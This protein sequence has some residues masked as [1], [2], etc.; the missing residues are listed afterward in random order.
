MCQITSHCHSLLVPLCGNDPVLTTVYATILCRVMQ[1]TRTA[2][3]KLSKALMGCRNAPR[4]VLCAKQQDAL[5]DA[6]ALAVSQ[7]RTIRQ[8]RQRKP[9]RPQ[10]GLTRAPCYRPLGPG[11]HPG[12]CCPPN[13]AGPL[14]RSAVG[15]CWPLTRPGALWLIPSDGTGPAPTN[16]QGPQQPTRP[17]GGTGAGSMDRQGW[18]P[19]R[20]RSAASLVPPSVRQC[21]RSFRLSAS[22][23]L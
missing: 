3:I 23:S 18:T 6:S 11:R 10:P 16:C 12:P 19:P 9:A 1:H 17:G 14:C 20:P 7:S 2:S 4:V 5:A 21:C 8:T 15:D 13:P 22:R